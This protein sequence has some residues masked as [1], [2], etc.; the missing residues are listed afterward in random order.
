LLIF[1]TAI[2]V[3]DAGVAGSNPAA[4]TIDFQAVFDGWGASSQPAAKAAWTG[5][6]AG[7]SPTD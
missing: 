1:S 3:R 5:G 2:Y 6:F 7:P 4:P